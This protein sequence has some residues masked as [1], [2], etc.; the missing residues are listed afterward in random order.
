MN[1]KKCGK[2]MYLR[3]KQRGTRVWACTA[4]SNTI[5]EMREAFEPEVSLINPNEYT[6]DTL[7]TKVRNGEIGLNQVPLPERTT[8]EKALK[9]P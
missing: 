6:L 9:Q 1:C 5:R 8:I 2:P 4:C 7:I 3:Y